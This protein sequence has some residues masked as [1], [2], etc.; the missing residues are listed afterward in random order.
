MLFSMIAAVAAPATSA[1]PR[2]PLASYLSANDYPAAALRVEAEGTTGVQLTI[3]TDGRVTGCEII[4]SAGNHSLDQA[5]CQLLQRRARFEP[6]KDGQGRSV[7]GRYSA[8]I[9]WR[10]PQSEPVPFVRN[11]HVMTVTLADGYARSCTLDSDLPHLPAAPGVLVCP[12][13]ETPVP[14]QL[15]RNGT[16][17]VTLLMEPRDGSPPVVLTPPERGVIGST[18]RAEIEVDARGRVQACSATLNGRP[19]PRPEVACGQFTSGRAIFEAA[20][21]QPLRR[22]TLTATARLHADDKR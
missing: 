19:H 15:P 3:G 6:A 14:P 21:T 22:A 2:A 13:T 11:R 17:T 12:S 9:S 8:S 18:V 10:L 16:M 20:P 4:A 1:M 7:E 5:T